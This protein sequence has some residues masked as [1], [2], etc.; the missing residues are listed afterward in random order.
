MNGKERRKTKVLKTRKKKR[1]QREETGDL[2][3]L[4][5]KKER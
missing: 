3:V 2:D 5:Q 4:R 1:I